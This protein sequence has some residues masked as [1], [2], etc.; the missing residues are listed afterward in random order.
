MLSLDQII[1]FYDEHNQGQNGKLVL[2]E[3]KLNEYR[4]RQT[5]AAVNNRALPNARNNNKLRFGKK[6][7]EF[8]NAPITKFWQNIFVYVLFLTCFTYIVLV[9][10]PVKPSAWEIFVLVYVFSCGLDKIRELI[11]TDS[12]RFSSKIKI[13]FANKINTLDV[14][15]ILSICVAL[16]FRLASFADHNK[17]ARIIYCVNTIYWSVKLF[18]F[19][20]INKYTGPLIIIASRMVIINTLLPEKY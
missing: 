7:Y 20:I 11:Q 4:R 14:V 2:D 6:I 15:F 19:L 8:Y 9:E 1:E 18:E 17:L 12:P 13:F 3:D 10:T 16:A 5:E